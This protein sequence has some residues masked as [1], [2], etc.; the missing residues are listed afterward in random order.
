M[1]APSDPHAEAAL[2]GGVLLGREDG[3]MR[4]LDLFAGGG[5]TAQGLD[6]AGHDAVGIEWDA[7][8][9]LTHIAAGYDC[10]FGDVRAPGLYSMLGEFDAVWSSFPCQ[11]WSTAG[12]REGPKGGRNG[13]PWTVD[14]LDEVKPQWFVGENVTGLMMHAGCDARCKGPDECPRAYLDRVIVEDLRQRFAWV[15]WRILDSADY[16]TPQFRRR[17]F[18]VA[19]PRPIEWP[20]ATHGKPSG[21]ADLF[22]HSLKPWTTVRDALG[23][24]VATTGGW[25][26]GRSVKV[27]S[28][29][30][31]PPVTAQQGKQANP[32]KSSGLPF[33]V[34]PKH[35][36][37]TLGAPSPALR[38]GGS[39]HSAPPM[40]L[41]LHRGLGMCERGG[42][43]PGTPTSIPSPAILA[44]SAGS[45]PLLLL[46][47]HEDPKSALSDGSESSRRRLSV[48]ECAALM[49]WP[50]DYPLQGNKS[51]RYRIVGNGVVPI[52]ARRLAESIEEAS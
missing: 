37:A 29:S 26:E 1:T 19:G 46:S 6:A 32:W 40:W 39:G 8:A 2:L 24:D 13:W 20:E 3:V 7:A 4:W 25:A 21:Q 30:P 35:P 38:S 15:E 17:I 49:G 51:D 12:K 42:F 34:D 50:A 33:A 43:R 45:G 44:G 11:D 52:V 23:L 18:I 9:Y 36:P 16:G 28:D 5:G 47:K 27:M 41:H 48:A 14:V 22:G 10:I 31:A